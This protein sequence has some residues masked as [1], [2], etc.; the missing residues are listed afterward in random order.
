MSRRFRKIG[1]YHRTRCRKACS[2]LPTEEQ[3]GHGCGTHE[4][5]VDDRGDVSVCMG[6]LPPLLAMEAQWLAT[7]QH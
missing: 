5:M 3:M 4:M 6:L 1:L 2:C 7:S